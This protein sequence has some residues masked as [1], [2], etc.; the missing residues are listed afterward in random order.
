M[1][2]FYQITLM[3][4]LLLSSITNPKANAQLPDKVLVGYWE[5]WGSV[6]IKD[7]DPRYNVI[8]LAFLEADKGGSYTDNVVGDLEFTPS[9]NQTLV[10]D[11]I[12][13]VQKKGKIVLF[14]IGGA[15]GSFKLNSVAD[16]NTFVEKV[17]LFVSAYGVD[18]IDLD[19]EQLTY[20][21]MTSGSMTSP[22]AHIQYLVDGCK[23]LLEW[24]QATYG[25]K[26]ILTTA[27]EVHYVQG[28][29]SQ[30]AD[31]GGS[32]LPFMELLKDEIDLV[33]VQLYNVPEA[34]DLN[35][36]TR[37]Q[38]TTTFIT[39]MTEAVIR[40]FNHAKGWGTYSG[41]PASKVVVALPACSGNGY[42]NSSDMVA[43]V[44]YLMGNGPKVGDYTLIQSGGYPDLRGTMTW[45]ANRDKTCGYAFA[46]ATEQIIGTIGVNQVE[47]NNQI[48]VYP[49]PS[50]DVLNIERKDAS[51]SALVLYDHTGAVVYQTNV[52]EL[53]ITMNIGNFSPG[54]YIL[55][56]DGASVKVTFN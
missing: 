50:S 54:L 16:K 17:K 9:I 4:I 22:Q 30:W 13:T 18:G 32:W 44:K 26:M 6:R 46:T 31:G 19:I 42:V 37:Y 45:S 8:M 2:H 10:K 15:N 49:N 47:A 33:M 48:S 53:N 56:L 20:L 21:R 39:A 25:K 1:R 24:Y 5:N 14:S 7:L 28:G 29:L 38:G 23:E 27:P 11:D 40:G 55:T 52:S 43:A 51:S 12:K 35:K 41:F 34:Y 3:S 36:V